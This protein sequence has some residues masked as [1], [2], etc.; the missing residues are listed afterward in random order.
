MHLVLWSRH[1]VSCTRHIISCARQNIYINA[2][3]QYD[4]PLITSLII[5]MTAIN[6]IIIHFCSKKP[7]CWGDIQKGFGLVYIIYYSSVH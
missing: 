1:H 6:N 2:Q 3:V 7:D 4:I 5:Y